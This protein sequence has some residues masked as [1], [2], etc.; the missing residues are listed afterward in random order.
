MKKSVLFLAFACLFVLAPIVHLTAQESEQ[1]SDDREV[2]EL[3]ESMKTM[4]K[5]FRQLG[6]QIGESS[7]NAD[8][9]QLVATMSEAANHA[10]TFKPEK[11]ADIS[12]KDQ[13]KFVADYQTGI[14]N[15]IADLDRLSVALK[16]N[17]N[18]E[19]S[20]IVHQLK[21]DQKQGHKAFRKKHDKK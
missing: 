19:A 1:H 9:L 12:E 11:T 10:L 14:K 18:V 20:R 13:T 21:D 8:S 16:A 3:G 5:A 2:T 15:L 17:D 4:Q 7:M 6:R